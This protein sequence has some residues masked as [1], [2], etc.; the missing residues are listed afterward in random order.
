MFEIDTS[1]WSSFGA[2]IVSNLSAD[3]DPLLWQ[4]AVETVISDAQTACQKR[5]G[6]SAIVAQVGRCSHW[7]APNKARWITQDGEFTWPSGYKSKGSFFSG[8]PEFDW[9]VV[10][11]YVD[12]SHWQPATL[13]EFKRPLLLQVAIPA[14]TG[15]HIRASVHAMW[16]PGPIS[17][18]N[19]RRLFY[20]FRKMKSG[21]QC[22]AYSGPKINGSA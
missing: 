6:R 11:H 7:L 8:L 2:P 15:L 16:S 13:S 17:S 22:R 19:Q 1:L 18:L 10:W 4:V 14:R 21:W 9:H 3:D 12:D 20:G 5:A